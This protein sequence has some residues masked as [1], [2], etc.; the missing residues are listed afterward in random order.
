M[1]E[2]FLGVGYHGPEFIAVKFFSVFSDAAVFED[3]RSRGVMIDPEGDGE[4]DRRNADAADYGEDDIKNAFQDLIRPE[5]EV[6]FQAEEH[7]FFIEEGE[8]FDIAHG[9]AYQIWND[10]DIFRHGLGPID[11]GGQIILGEA[12]GCDEDV[13]DS[14]ISYDFF[15]IIK[16][17]E[18][19]YFFKEFGLGMAAVFQE[20]DG[21]IGHAGGIFH[22]PDGCIG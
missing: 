20:S 13:P 9:Y 19:G 14:C 4:K 2:D 11:E 12:G 10:I 21:M 1:F 3:D 18:D 22:F 6:I 17:A 7:D 5:G 15:E 16:A 8:G